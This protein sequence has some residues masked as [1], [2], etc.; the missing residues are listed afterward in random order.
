MAQAAAF[1]GIVLT[2]YVNILSRRTGASVFGRHLFANRQLWLALSISS[3]VVTVIVSVPAVGLWF[4]F[5]PMRLEHWIWPI[6]GALVFLM[7]FEG[8]KWLARRNLAPSP[9]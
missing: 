9:S 7:C 6:T 8:R 5:E 4:G 1:T 2:Q 3:V